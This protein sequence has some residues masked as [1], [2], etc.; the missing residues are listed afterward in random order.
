MATS[1]VRAAVKTFWRLCY[2]AKDFRE[3]NCK[4]NYAVW[5][6]VVLPKIYSVEVY[7]AKTEMF[8]AV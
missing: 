1:G 3:E 5:Y 4:G 6:V 7:S 2:E 8:I